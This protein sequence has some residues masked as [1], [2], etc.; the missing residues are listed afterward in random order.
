MLMPNSRFRDS[1][2]SHTLSVVTISDIR[3][4]CSKISTSF[5]ISDWLAVSL[6]ATSSLGRMLSTAASSSAPLMGLGR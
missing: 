3:L 5:P 6:K 1:G 2:R 4:A